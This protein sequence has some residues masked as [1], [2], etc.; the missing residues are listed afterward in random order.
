M[1]Q[2]SILAAGAALAIAG[3]AGTAKAQDA[4]ESAIILSGNAGTGGAQRSLGRSI[5]GSIGNAAN[6]VRV[7]NGGNG[8]GTYRAPRRGGGSASTGGR[9]PAG[10]DPLKGTDASSY[11]LSNGAGIKVSGH[12]TPNAGTRCVSHC[13]KPASGGE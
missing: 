11:R 5:S 6:A 8:G 1:R 13:P 4:A 3:G 9:I 12:M 10:V 7:G 2:I